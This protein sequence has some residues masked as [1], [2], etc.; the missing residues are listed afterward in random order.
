MVDELLNKF[1]NEGFAWLSA[2]LG[3]I[4]ALKYVARQCL[5]KSKENKEFF[6]QLNKYMRKTHIY[7]GIALI[8]TGV[9]HGYFSS[10]DVLSLNLG[11]LCWIMSILL[12][13]SYAIRK[14]LSK[15]AKW[16]KYHRVLTIL[17]LL[18]LGLHLIDIKIYNFSRLI[19]NRNVEEHFDRDEDESNN[20]VNISEISGDFS[21]YTFKDGTYEGVAEGYGG[22]LT[23]SVTV[24]NNKI[25]DVL[26]V[27]H[28]EKGEHHYGRAME[29][30]PQEIVDE[31]SADV[32]IVSGATYT[33][34]GIINA[35]KDALMKAVK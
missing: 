15:P 27:S 24:K 34:N 33:S 13:I 12:G 17:F 8:I 18:T 21:N 31:Q 16:M 2:L 10:D 23:V 35:V 4:L 19:N 11:T 7:M 32:D 26:V 14:S 30:V 28:N 3:G 1:L 22:P 20:N 29:M 9:I 25:T 5:I 6:K